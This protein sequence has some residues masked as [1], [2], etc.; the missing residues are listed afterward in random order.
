M[1]NISFF[2]LTPGAKDQTQVYVS[3]SRKLAGDNKR[4]RFATGE[5]F[6]AGYCHVR[7]K[8][9]GK[10]LVKRNTVFYFEYSDTLSKIRNNLVRIAME[11]EKAGNFSLEEVKKQYYTQIG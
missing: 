3:I 7:K 6:L 10:E 9:N 5:S 2:L 8:K 4:L 1:L 11:L